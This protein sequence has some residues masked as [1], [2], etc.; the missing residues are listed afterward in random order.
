MCI[1]VEVQWLSDQNTSQLLSQTVNRRWRQSRQP[2]P[3][4]WMNLKVEILGRKWNFACGA[5]TRKKLRIKYKLSAIY[6]SS[7]SNLS[8]IQTNKVLF[9]D[10]KTEKNLSQENK[11]TQFQ[12]FFVLLTFFT[13]FFSIFFF[14]VYKTVFFFCWR[15]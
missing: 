13:F 10:E 9:N 3:P 6:L 14:V 15:K 4:T 8:T 1:R 12:T 5:Q 2:P 7:M 11:L